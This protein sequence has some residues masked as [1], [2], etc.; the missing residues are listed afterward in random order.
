MLDIRVHTVLEGLY[1]FSKA[2]LERVHDI[3]GPHAI[4][5]VGAR[6][7][8][9]G[10]RHARGIPVVREPLH[11]GRERDDSAARMHG[12]PAFRRAA[13]GFAA[14]SRRVEPRE[15]ERVIVRVPRVTLIPHGELGQVCVAGR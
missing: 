7:N 8:P 14:V 15:Q 2:L 12:Q 1:A 5:L 10:F 9:R 13:D 3:V 6:I 11:I 4:L